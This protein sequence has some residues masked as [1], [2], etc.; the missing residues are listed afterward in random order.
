VLHPL[1]YMTITAPDARPIERD[2]VTCCHC[3]RIVIVKPGTAATVYLEPQR[4]GSPDRETPGAFCRS[5][6]KAVCLAC[7]AVG[8]CLPFELAIERNEARGRQLRAMG[9]GA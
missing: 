3:Q 2:T 6:M 1:G 7:E 9:I 4:D 8:R 5:C